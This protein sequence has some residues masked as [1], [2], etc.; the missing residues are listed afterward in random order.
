LAPSTTALRDAVRGIGPFDSGMTLLQR[1]GFA[2]GSFYD[3]K[4]T[5]T[6]SENQQKATLLLQTDQVRVGMAGNLANYQFI[7]RNG[8]LVTGAQVDYNGSPAGYNLDPQEDIV[9]ISKHDNQTLFDI[10]VYA[11]PQATSMADRVRIQ[12]WA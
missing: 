11:A 2:N 3:S 1:Q 7:D 8:N 5:V 9:Y 10:N 12:T 4:P 6:G